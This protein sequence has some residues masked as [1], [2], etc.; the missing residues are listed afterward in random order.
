MDGNYAEH[1]RRPHAARAIPD[2]ARSSAR[3]L[4]AARSPAHDQGLRPHPSRICRRDVRSVSTLRSCATCGTS[5]AEHRPRIA[6]GIEQFGSHLRHNP[7]CLRSRRRAFPGRESSLLMPQFSTKRRVRH[8][9]AEMFDLVADV[10]RYPEF[11]PL[12][13]ALKVR[14]RTAGAGRHRGAGRRDDGRL[15]ADQRDVHQPRH[16]RPAQS[17]DTGRIPRRPVQ[18]YGEP[19][20]LS[21]GRR[22]QLR[23]RILHLL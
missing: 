12:C 16:P 15:Q 6:A 23:R 13:R 5:R 10:E 7:A 17:A 3:N 21:S 1:L 14:Q 19:L 11:V 8:A 2:L 20:E 18:P 4:H 22:A 9:A